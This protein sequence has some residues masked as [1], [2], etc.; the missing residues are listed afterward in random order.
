MEISEWALA[1]PC[2]GFFWHRDTEENV[3]AEHQLGQ[4]V[5]LMSKNLYICLK[6]FLFLIIFSVFHFA[7]EIFPSSVLVP[8]CAINESIWQH[9][10][11]AFF[12]YF[13]LNLVEFV[14]KR[15]SIQNKSSF[16]FSRLFTTTLIPWFVF[17]LWYTMAAFYGRLEILLLEVI[18]ASIVTLL[19][20]TVCAT[21]ELDI[22]D[23]HFTRNFK[24]FI[25]II[26]VI[27]A[28]LYVIFT[29]KLP[30]IDMFVV[31]EMIK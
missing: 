8:I 5:S 12:S 31:P 30:W 29:Y 3:A 14:F 18:F 24:A 20:G 21:I 9:L 2:K 23:K 28:S 27:S 26:F 11:I 15:R 17:I 22:E 16:I 25:L 4:R 6:G 1:F 13:V 19:S 10:K 7:Y